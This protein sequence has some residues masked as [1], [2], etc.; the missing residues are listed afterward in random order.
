MPSSRWSNPPLLNNIR[1][2]RCPRSGKCEDS[3]IGTGDGNDKTNARNSTAS[4]EGND[5]ATN[6][7]D[8][9]QKPLDT[10]SLQSFRLLY[11]I[12]SAQLDLFERHDNGQFKWRARNRNGDDT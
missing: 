12:M 2:D 9:V 7:F 8:V 4:A 6:G 11:S 10:M 1:Y 3:T 5:H